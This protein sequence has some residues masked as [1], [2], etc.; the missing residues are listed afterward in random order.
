MGLILLCEQG[1][2][3]RVTTFEGLQWDVSHPGPTQHTLTAL[4]EALEEQFAPPAAVLL[5]TGDAFA[6][7]L[8]AS[9]KQEYLHRA[10][11]QGKAAWR[12]D[13]AT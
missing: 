3:R 10:Q 7:W 12:I 5:C 6:G 2:I 4:C 13:T 11:N 8:A 9:D 1:L